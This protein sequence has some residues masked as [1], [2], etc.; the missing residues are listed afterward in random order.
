MLTNTAEFCDHFASCLPVGTVFCEDIPVKKTYNWTAIQ[1]YCDGGHSS[2]E[3]M[4]QFGMS[5]LGLRKAAARKELR[6]SDEFFVDPRPKHDWVAIKVYYDSGKSMRE[7][8][9]RFGFC[10]GSWSKAVRRG[11]IQPRP[12]GVPIEELLAG[13]PSLRR[14]RKRLLHAGLIKNEC[15]G[16]GLREWRGVLLRLRLEYVNNVRNDNRLENLRLVCP[17][18]KAQAGFL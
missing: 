4:R 17:N 14:M 15:S 8:A 3:C 1:Q 2:S 18:C 5:R 10:I 7:C 16:C 13:S 11:D 6:V 12:N 9:K